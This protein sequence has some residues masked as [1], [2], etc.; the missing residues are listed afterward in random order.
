M[1]KR[2]KIELVK[3]P[4]DFEARKAL[5]SV[6]KAA[7]GNEKVYYLERLFDYP[8]YLRF[9]HRGLLIGFRGVETRK[10]ED[11]N[12]QMIIEMGESFMLPAYDDKALIPRLTFKVLWSFWKERFVNFEIGS[13]E[14]LIG[15]S[16]PHRLFTGIK[17]AFDFSQ[18]KSNKGAK[19]RASK[20]KS[21]LLLSREARNADIH[22]YLEN[23]PG[24]ASNLLEK[25][26]Q[27]NP[28]AGIRLLG[29]NLKQTCKGVLSTRLFNKQKSHL[30]DQSFT[31]YMSLS[32]N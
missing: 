27:L 11:S 29:I 7:K 9:W 12:K 4:L 24:I 19:E 17:Q 30:P 1:K 23:T 2:I 15:K 20:P 22:F 21:F 3:S 5:L 32:G 10:L 16:L 14:S 8:Y 18:S 25:S 6:Y 26:A 31:E 28:Q 13:Q